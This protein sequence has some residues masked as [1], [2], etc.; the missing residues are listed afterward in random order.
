MPYKRICHLFFIFKLTVN[1]LI[2]K[3][4][5]S[6]T[7]FKIRLSTILSVF[8]MERSG[9]PTKKKNWGE[10]GRR[11]ESPCKRT[12]LTFRLLLNIT[13]LQKIESTCPL[14]TDHIL[15]KK[16]LDKFYQ[17]FSIRHT[18]SVIQSWIFWKN[19]LELNSLIQNSVQQDYLPEFYPIVPINIHGKPWR[20]GR[21]P[22]NIQ[23]MYLFT[24][25]EKSP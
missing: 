21:I 16:V 3:K 17:K 6:P 12:G 1:L 14:I 7:V 4:I 15:E 20:W 9:C 25:P 13:H 2:W 23:K 10:G 18:F 8:L 19:L 5:L 22:P 24:P 11:G